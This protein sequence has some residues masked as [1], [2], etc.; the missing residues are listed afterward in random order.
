METM[1]ENTLLSSWLRTLGEATAFD[2]ATLENAVSNVPLSIADVQQY[3]RFD[4]DHYI[5][6]LW[7][8]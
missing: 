6:L 8:V 2:V 1:F 4:L 5:R 3:V 7:S